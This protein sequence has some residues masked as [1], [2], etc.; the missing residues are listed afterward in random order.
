MVSTLQKQQSEI[1][2]LAIKHTKEYI[3]NETGKTGLTF[4]V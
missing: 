4:L 1:G 2:F 3:K